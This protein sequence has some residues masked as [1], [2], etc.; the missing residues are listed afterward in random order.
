VEEPAPSK[1]KEGTTDSLH[2]LTVEALVTSRGSVPSD[3]KKKWNCAYGL[4]K[5]SSLKKGVM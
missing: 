1:M 5:M 2:A 4:L 3:W